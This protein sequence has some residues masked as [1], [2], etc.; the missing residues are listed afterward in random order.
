MIPLPETAGRKGVPLVADLDPSALT[1]Q[2]G[3]QRRTVDFDSFDI[4]VQQLLGMLDEAQRQ[5]ANQFLW[6]PMGMM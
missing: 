2:L 1:Q 5:A 4:H 3:A 6:G